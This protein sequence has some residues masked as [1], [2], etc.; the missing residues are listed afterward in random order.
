MESAGEAWTSTCNSADS[1]R[2]T[3]ELGW[4]AATS[5]TARWSSP[6]RQIPAQRLF[7]QT[8]RSNMPAATSSDGWAPKGLLQGSSG[9]P[10]PPSS[11]PHLLNQDRENH[12]GHVQSQG[13]NLNPRELVHA[14]CF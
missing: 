10:V 11:L 6:R 9:L 14:Q 8:A 3:P 2:A 4:R 1:S 13:L 7:I 5:H 12:H